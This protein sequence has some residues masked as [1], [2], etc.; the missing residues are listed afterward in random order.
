MWLDGAS[1]RPAAGSGASPDTDDGPGAQL[2]LR[3]ARTPAALPSHHRSALPAIPLDC[4]SAASDRPASSRR[5]FRGLVSL[6]TIDRT[7]GEYAV[8]FHS[9]SVQKIVQ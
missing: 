1:G 9:Q 6:G 7:P 3:I 8:T 5:P 4:V 2:L